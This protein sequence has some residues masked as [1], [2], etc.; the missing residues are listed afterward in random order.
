MIKMTGQNNVNDPCL[1]VLGLY[2]ILAVSH[3]RQLGRTGYFR[4]RSYWN[5]LEELTMDKYKERKVSE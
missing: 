1:C 2:C 3:V 5:L 4:I